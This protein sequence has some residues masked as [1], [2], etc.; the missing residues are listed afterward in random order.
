MSLALAWLSRTSGPPVSMRLPLSLV[1]LLV[2]KIAQPRNYNLGAPPHQNR[3]VTTIVLRVRYGQVFGTCF[4][5]YR[6]S[7]GCTALSKHQDLTV[8]FLTWLVL[9]QG[10]GGITAHFFLITLCE[11]GTVQIRRFAS[12]VLLESHA[13]SPVASHRPL[14]LVLD[15]LAPDGIAVKLLLLEAQAPF[16]IHEVDPS[17]ESC[18]SVANPQGK[19][20][21]WLDADATCIW[22]AN[23]IMRYVC[24]KHDLD[25]QFYFSDDDNLKWRTDM[26]STIFHDPLQFSPSP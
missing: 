18:V 19:L 10:G 7:R 24:D 2:G 23:A 9:A 16:V 3:P 5:W 22:E 13:M 17:R 25:P 4:L 6:A 8:T 26:V 11:T 1:A 20:P 14:Q 21:C 12:G 15:P